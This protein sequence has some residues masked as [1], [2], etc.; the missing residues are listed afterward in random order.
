MTIHKI[1][2]DCKYSQICTA[3][4]ARGLNGINCVDYYVD[5]CNGEISYSLPKLTLGINTNGE[6]NNYHFLNYTNLLKFLVEELNKENNN[7]VS[8]LRT[9]TR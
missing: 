5:D 3:D 4:L 6:V 8:D 2:D 9:I 1:C 7:W